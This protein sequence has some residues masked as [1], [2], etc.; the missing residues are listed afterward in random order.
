MQAIN[1]LPK[2]K[3][4]LRDEEGIFNNSAITPLP[5]SPNTVIKPVNIHNRLLRQTSST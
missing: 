3:P 2:L 1:D 5:P 4:S